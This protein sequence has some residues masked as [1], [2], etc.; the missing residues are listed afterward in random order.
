M[1]KLGTWVHNANCCN[2]NVSGTIHG[3]ERFAERGFTK[4]RIEEMVNDYT[5]KGY[6]PGGATVYIKKKNDGSYDVIVINKD[7]ELITA[8]GGN[9]SRQKLPNRA[10]VMKMLKNH[11]GFSGIPVD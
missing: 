9:E 7:N 4:T 2:I 3:G 1:G 11:G 6:Q 8:V 5:E 10:A